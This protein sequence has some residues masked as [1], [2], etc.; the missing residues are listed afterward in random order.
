M[1]RSLGPAYR[2]L[3]ASSAA[4]NLADGV[5]QLTLPLLALDLTG[6]A[7]AVAAVGVALGLPWLL[8][9]L[10]AGALVDRLDR[11][12]VM[13]VAQLGRVVL[14]GTLAVAVATDFVAPWMLYVAAFAI[15]VMETIFDT[16][17]QSITPRI[18]D[19]Q[20]LTHANGRLFAIETT[21]HQFV[22]PPV[23][24][25][26]MSVGVALSLGTSA[27][28]FF[29]AALVLAGL[30]GSFRAVRD[31]VAVT[32]V[33]ADIVDGLRFLWGHRVLRRLVIVGAVWNACATGAFAL[34]AVL[35]VAPGPLGLSEFGFGLL[36]TLSAAGSVLGSYVVEAA[37]RLVGRRRLLL[38]CAPVNGGAL[39]LMATAEIAVVVPASIVLGAG[40]VCWNVIVVT[41]RQRLIPDHL[42][43]RV[44]AASRM[45]SWGMMPVGAAVGAV[46]VGVVDVTTVYAISGSVVMLLVFVLRGL[47]ERELETGDVGVPVT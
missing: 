28:C 12:V 30:P 4:S 3:C 38:L 29:V 40:L 2:R 21:M 18:V 36:L 11:R 33:R 45:A 35:A 24:G 39:A 42:L 17:A 9:A 19:R 10:H 32:G 7:S 8:F 25:A 27:A 26:L 41:L 16:S 22:G 14:V 23:G 43:G 20:D 6:S 46:L 15:G 47:T 1:S 13:V 31:D 5:L 44:N 34:L 37:E